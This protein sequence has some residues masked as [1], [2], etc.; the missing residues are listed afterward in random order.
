M[1]AKNK[2]AKPAP[3]AADI[4]DESIVD[5]SSAAASADAGSISEQELEDL[6]A[7]AG[8]ADENWD[9]FLR[10]T[11]EFE[12]YRKRVAR[13]KEELARFT[14]ER[15]LSALLP[16][17]D[18]LERAINAA[19]QHGAENSPLLEGITQVHNQFRRSLV[20]LGIREIVANVGEPF[21]PNLHEAVGRVESAEHPEGH[22][23]EQLQ[24]GYKLADRLL[25]PARVV[26]SK[27]LSVADEA[28]EDSGDAGDPA[29]DLK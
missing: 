11:A 4:E 5:T 3:T 12:N 16:V 24:P 28:Q 21:D 15:V 25:R 7:K 27:G 8:K 6:R 29:R 23:V 14:S 20:D 13:E 19:Q 22:V 26:V 18:N 17:L 10:A 9:K 2:H 1:T